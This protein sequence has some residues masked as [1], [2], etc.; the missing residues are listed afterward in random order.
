MPTVFKYFDIFVMVLIIK[1]DGVAVRASFE[2]K[3]ILITSNFNKCGTVNWAE[4]GLQP[5][6][7]H[8]YL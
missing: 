6:L 5:E 2:L 3:V 7:G 8:K 4:S 1:C